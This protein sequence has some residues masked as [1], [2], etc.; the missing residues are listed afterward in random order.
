MDLKQRVKESPI[1]AFQI[2]AIALCFVLNLVDGY[3]VVVMPLWGICS[4][5]RF[6]AWQLAPSG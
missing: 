3:D 2:R 4:V 1:T 6:L 5:P